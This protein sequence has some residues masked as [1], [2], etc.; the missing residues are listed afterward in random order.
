M[1]LMLKMKQKPNPEKIV[2]TL[3]QRNCY[4][5]NYHRYHTFTYNATFVE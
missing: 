4:H 3:F 2:E 5:K 1:K